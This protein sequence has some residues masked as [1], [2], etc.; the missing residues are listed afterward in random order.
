QVAQRPGGREP[1]GGGSR[2][3]L[4]E[5]DDGNVMRIALRLAVVRIAMPGA[6]VGRA[7]LAVERRREGHFD[8]ADAFVAVLCGQEDTRRDERARALLPGAVGERLLREQGSDLGMAV[9]VWRTVG[10][11][12]R[13]P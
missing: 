3:S 1:C 8:P 11:S 10:D 2:D 4:I 12:Q 6:P 9:A 13:S 7:L 5:H